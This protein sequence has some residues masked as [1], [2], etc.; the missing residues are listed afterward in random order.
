[1]SEKHTSSNNNSNDTQ[2]IKSPEVPAD[3]NTSNPNSVNNN[4]MSS[5]T[6]SSNANST[7]S[8]TEQSEVS[9]VLKK[10]SLSNV[11]K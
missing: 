6:N 9:G 5:N 3:T 1:M 2:V 11:T 7:I 8:S 4:P 10:I